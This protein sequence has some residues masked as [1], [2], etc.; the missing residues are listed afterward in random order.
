MEQKPLSP[1]SP[2]IHELKVWPVY[3]DAIAS[4]RKRFEMRFEFDRTFAEGDVLRLRAYDPISQ[5]YMNRPTLVCDVGFI[6][7]DGF[8]V[9]PG[10]ACMSISNVVPVVE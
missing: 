6:L 7:R 8:G 1:P 5:E 2:T 9:S 10:F 3:Y 4:G